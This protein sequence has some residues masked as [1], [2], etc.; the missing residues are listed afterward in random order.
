MN[1]MELFE[2]AGWVAE[3]LRA[4][5]RVLVHC[6]AGVNRS[7]TVCCA[8]LMFLEGIGPEEALARVR[9]HHPVAWPD[10]YHWFI[11]RW[12]AQ[13]LDLGTPRLSS[14]VTALVT[15]ESTFLR[16]GTAIG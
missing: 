6:Y 7:S 9:Q 10:P 12:L 15:Q 4:G 3:R 16:E 11:L 5:H 2:E 1:A 8:T 14:E 13:A